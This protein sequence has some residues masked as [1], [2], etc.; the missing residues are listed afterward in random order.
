MALTDQETREHV[1]RVD[2]LLE[3]IEA[4]DETAEKETAL[5]IVQALVASGMLMALV[6]AL[7]SVELRR[8]FGGGWLLAAGVLAESVVSMLTTPVMMVMQGVA[9]IDVLIDAQRRVNRRHL[10]EGQARL[11]QRHAGLVRLV[12]FSKRA[13]VI[14]V[15]RDPVARAGFCQ[16]LVFTAKRQPVWRSACPPD[17]LSHR[18]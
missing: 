4:W 12:H 9:V 15:E 5:N 3:Q 6:L 1:A 10:G 13:V 7:Q 11:E 16:F 18:W 2:A 8:G 14:R 17:R